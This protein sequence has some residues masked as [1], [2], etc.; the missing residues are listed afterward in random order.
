MIVALVLLS[1]CSMR[2]FSHYVG[3]LDYSAVPGMFITESN[4]VSF[5]YQPVGSILVMEISGDAKKEKKKTKELD[6]IYGDGQDHSGEI[7]Y[8]SAG[9]WRY[10]NMQSA[11]NYAAERAKELGGNGIINLRTDVLL[12][13][14][15]HIDKAIVRGMVIKRK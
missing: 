4:S 11:L 5:E 14:H 13:E 15:N 9:N 12:D 7:Y 6:D 8:V 3:L 2:Q 1:G 10:A